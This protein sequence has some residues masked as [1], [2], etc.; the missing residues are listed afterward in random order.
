M[1]RYHFISFHIIL[2]LFPATLHAD[3]FDP[4]SKHIRPGNIVIIGETHQKPESPQFF[5]QLVDEAIAKYQ[6]L[7]I[8]LEIERDQQATID[9]VMAGRLPV[10]KI[11][12]SV[13]IDHPGYRQL[14]VQL[15]EIKQR[16]PCVIVEAI[17]ADSDR[18]ENMAKWLADF[19]VDRPILALLGGLH[20]LKKVDWTVASGKPSV[21]EILVNR[22]FTVKTYPQ[23]WTPE[24]C[25]TGQGRVSRYMSAD[26]LEAL[27]ILN[28]S[29]M[30]LLNAKPHQSTKGVIDGFVLWKCNR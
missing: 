12:V 22:G 2:F 19:P 30:S 16:S 29:L 18:Y 11:E 27:Q 23:L 9:D 17:Y 15:A 24:K 6:C 28:K 26:N 7:S 14:L 4:I 21:A 3:T 5:K 13:V 10:S 1:N 8:G 25:G 20:T